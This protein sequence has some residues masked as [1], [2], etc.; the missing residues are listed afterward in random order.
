MPTLAPF[1]NPVVNYG[2]DAHDYTAEAQSLQRRRSVSDAMLKRSLDPISVPVAKSANE[3]SS[4]ISPFAALAKLGETYMANKS[5]ER[6]DTAEGSLAARY[7]A[8]ENKEIADFTSG[9]T[10][11]LKHLL[12]YSQSQFAPTRAAALEMLK[13]HQKG[14]IRPKDILTTPKA[15]LASRSAGAQVGDVSKLEADPEYHV[16]PEGGTAISTVPGDPSKQTTILDKGKQYEKEADGVTPKLY[17]IKDGDRTISAQREIGTGKLEVIDKGNKISISNALDAGQKGINAGAE[18]IWKQGAETIGDLAKQARA[19]RNM[20]DSMKRMRALDDKGIYSGAGAGFKTFATN[21][22]DS[23][24]S[25]IGVPISKEMRDNLSNSQT[26][27]SV[28]IEAWQQLVGQMGGNRGITEQE[29]AKIRLIVPQLKNSVDARK[30]MYDILE[31]AATRSNEKFKKANTA[32]TTALKKNDPAEWNEY[33]QTMFDPEADTPTVPQM[34]PKGLAAPS[35]A[36][37]AGGGNPGQDQTQNIKS[38]EREL[39]DP[40]KDAT[41]K[42]ILNEELANAKKLQEEFLGGGSSPSPAAPAGGSKYEKYRR[43]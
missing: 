14:V 4:V 26:F 22:A 35:G 15:S 25:M 10:N 18:A 1:I 19:A 28:G 27:N 39:A 38:L 12:K 29:A 3:L 41:Q 33:F 7:K 11:D 34:K 5:G 21:M 37:P 43:K 13:E 32:Y 2:T 31:N 17:E 20:G 9:D 8:A 30:Q 6:V 16:V 40:T 36:A 23:V 42:Q 24:G